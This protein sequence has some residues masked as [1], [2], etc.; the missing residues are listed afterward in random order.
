MSHLEPLWRYE[1]HWTPS[2]DSP[3]FRLIRRSS[4][5]H[6]IVWLE[7]PGPEYAGLPSTEHVLEEFYGGLLAMMEATA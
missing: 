2:A 5:G 6:L 7:V 3:T 1:L 4:E